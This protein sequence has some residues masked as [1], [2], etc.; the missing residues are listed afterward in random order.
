MV[1]NLKKRL[2]WLAG[3]KISHIIFFVLFISLAYISLTAPIHRIGDT[4]TYYMQIQSIANDFDIKYEQKDLQRTFENK[5]DDLPAGLFLIKNAEGNYFYG[6]DY[7]YA[8]FAAPFFKIFGTNGILLFN[9]LMVF[10]MIY[11][12]YIFLKRKNSNHVALIFSTFYFFASVVFLYIFWISAE[13]FNM[14]LITLGFFLWSRYTDS[15]SLNSQKGEYPNKTSQIQNILLFSTAFI[16]GLAAFAKIPNAILVIPLLILEF[17]NKRFKNLILCVL[18][19]LMPIIILYGIFYLITGNI[20]PY[21][22]DRFLFISQFPFMEGYSPDIEIGTKTVS[23]GENTSLF[24]ILYNIIKLKL[25]YINLTVLSYDI[26]YFIF[27]R[28]IGIAW[29]YMPAIIALYLM[30][31]SRVEYYNSYLKTKFNSIKFNIKNLL[32]LLAL[33][34]NIFFYF[35]N[36]PTSFFGAI[37]VI[38]NRYFYIYPA[39]LF[40]VDKIQFD[41]KLIILFIFAFLF[42][43]PI[44]I[45]QE[46]NSIWP[47]MH[48]TKMPYSVLPIEYNLLDNL[49]FWGYSYNISEITYYFLDDSIEMITLQEKK[50]FYVNRPDK[51]TLLIKSNKLLQDYEF[52]V[53]SFVD[54]NKI[55]INIGSDKKQIIL[56]K[57]ENHTL[58]FFPKSTFE[59]EK[60]VLYEI[61]IETNGPILL[62]MNNS[63]TPY[64]ITPEKTIFLKGWNELEYWNGIP[65]RW[66]ENDGIIKMYSFEE[67]SDLMRFNVTNFYKPRGIQIYL[68]DKLISQTTIL[69]TE[70]I[71]LKVNLR[72]GEN[73]LRFYTPD[74]CQRPID[75][76]ESNNSDPRC[77]SFAIQNITFQN[78]LN[79]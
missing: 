42:T 58:I 9:A 57:S 52:N 54:N 73:I 16:F 66:I 65:A 27:G 30:F 31:S 3:I 75:V 6:K 17:Y 24:Y 1:D 67:K 71:T 53:F 34:L 7:S 72:E 46:D 49:P 68:N 41:K 23:I 21:S 33:I 2:K 48:T 14:F 45:N 26:F 12:G 62:D 70:E 51:T 28:F 29:Y 40:L 50:L 43:L 44:N 25:D 15:Y 77:L 39:F 35:I 38:G 76:P 8:L 19:F 63:N 69:S 56:N 5:F 11:M 4:S 47:A 55:K 22:G 59:S 79:K 18:S 20:S 36:S 64:I 74:G 32:I 78:T 60:Y 61:S 37:H 13:I 10:L